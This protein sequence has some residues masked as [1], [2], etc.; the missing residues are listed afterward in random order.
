MTNLIAWNI[1]AGGGR[2]VER[3]A[4]QITAWGADVVALS[5]FR[6]TPP[7]QWLAEALAGTGLIHQR[8]TADPAN[9]AVNALLVA[10]RWPLEDLSLFGAPRPRQR[11]LPVRVLAEEP[12]AVGAVHIPIFAFRGHTKYAFHRAVLRFARSWRDGPALVAGD[13]NTGRIGIDEE[14]PVF[15]KQS[16]GWMVGMERAGWAD[17]FRRLHGD[18]RAYTWYSPNAGNGFRL[19]EAFVNQAL[20]P[21]LESARYQWA[22][23]G[24]NERRDAVSDHAAL[25]LGLTDNDGASATSSRPA[26]GPSR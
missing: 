15:S 12:F 18:T 3:I 17:A 2:R 5:E 23:D 22:K 10:S 11:W 26:P 6:G 19:D 7:S 16:D 9:A 1:R 4:E 8:T 20:I 24:A 21:R 14:S 25:L 13:T